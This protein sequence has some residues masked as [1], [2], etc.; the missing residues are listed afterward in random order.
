MESDHG[1]GWVPTGLDPALD[2][3]VAD[4]VPPVA[5]DATSARALE[6][7]FYA[8]DERPPARVWRSIEDALRRDGLIR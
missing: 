3:P 7:S 4:G 1:A 8:E 5:G 6:A 2:E